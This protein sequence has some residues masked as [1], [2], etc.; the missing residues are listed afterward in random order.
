MKAGECL[1]EYARIPKESPHHVEPAKYDR[2]VLLCLRHV[3]LMGDV[4][5]GYLPKARMWVH[6]N[7]RM[8]QPRNVQHVSR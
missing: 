6:I 5:G 2:L 1:L 7:T 3:A 4:G 8:R